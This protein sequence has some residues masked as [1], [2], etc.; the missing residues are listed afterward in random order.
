MKDSK[1]INFLEDI[2]NIY[3]F[4]LERKEKIFS[5]LNYVTTILVLLIGIMSYFILNIHE[6]IQSNLIIPVFTFIIFFSISIL[7][8]IIAFCYILKSL[9]G[10][11]YNIL[12]YTK[13]IENDINKIREFSDK[14][15]EKKKD[16]NMSDE[17]I[18][19]QYNFIIIL[20][21]ISIQP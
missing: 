21:Q 10:Y 6:I 18:Q 9:F 2:Q 4:E 7:F 15:L 12:P 16:S 11:N 5:R 3:Y 13:D 1:K 8:I 17:D 19:E 14:V 20:L